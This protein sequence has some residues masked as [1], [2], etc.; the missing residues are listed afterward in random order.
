MPS[1]KRRTTSKS[2]NS[3]SS[4]KT[5]TSRRSASSSQTSPA[6]FE[7]VFGKPDSPEVERL[8][9]LLTTAQG[10]LAIEEAR[11]VPSL[12]L[13]RTR[14]TQRLARLR[15]LDQDRP[16]S[17]QGNRHQRHRGPLR[18][19]RHRTRTRWTTHHRG[20]HRTPTG[21]SGIHRERA[22]AGE[23]PRRPPEGTA[24]QD[25]GGTAGFD[26][27]GTNNHT[28]TAGTTAGA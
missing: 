21:P 13:Y 1:T 23:A 28:H 18:H 10:R 15:A 5:A 26:A 19:R 14:H 20:L 22:R 12:A 24:D 8:R 9:W 2:G 6:S 4:R 16:E 27:S 17:G 11:P 25:H 3:A 7:Q